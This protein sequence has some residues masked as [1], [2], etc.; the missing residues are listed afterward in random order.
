MSNFHFLSGQICKIFNITK[1]TLI[2]YDK[3]NLIKPSYVNEKTKYRYYSL[4]QFPKFYLIL[5]LKA[6]GFSLNDIQTILSNHSLETTKQMLTT[7]IETL[8]TEIKK[9]KTMKKSLEHN[10]SRIKEGETLYDPH[11]IYQKY[12]KDQYLFT[13]DI[14]PN[15]HTNDFSLTFSKLAQYH[16]KGYTQMPWSYGWVVTLDPNRNFLVKKISI[17]L[18]NPYKSKSCLYKPEGLYLCAYHYGSYE[19]LHETRNT[20]LSYAREKKLAITGFIYETQIINSFFTNDP[21]NYVTEVSIS[22]Y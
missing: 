21:S 11:K 14:D 10:L 13:L 17:K 16:F 18:D 22:I 12:I 3:I 19:N 9:L 20:L 1:Q 7:Q 8:S 15:D 5:S 4:N 6:S 2:F